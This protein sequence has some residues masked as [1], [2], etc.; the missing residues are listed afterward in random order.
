MKTTLALA[1]A[2]AFCLSAASAQ[3]VNPK[4]A[5]LHV[6]ANDGSAFGNRI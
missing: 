4:G 5:A 2:F 1:A 6:H 3:C